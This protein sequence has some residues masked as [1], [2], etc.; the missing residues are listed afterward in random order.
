MPPTPVKVVNV[1]TQSIDKH[2]QAQG[3]IKAFREVILQSDIAGKVIK[4]NLFE[5]QTVQKGDIIVQ[6]D[7][8]VYQAKLKQAQAK[9]KHSQQ[10]YLRIKTLV[11]KGTGSA[12]EAEDAAA[13]LK[14][15]EAEVALATINVDKTQIKAPFSG[16]LGLKDV[17]VGDYITPGQAL[18]NLVDINTIMVD[19]HLP[20]KYIS[21]IQEKM[22]VNLV[23]DS[24]PG[25]VFAGVIYA[26]APTLDATMR[27]LHARAKFSNPKFLLKPGLFSRLHIILATIDKALIIPEEAL[28]YQESKF[29]VYTI[30]DG[31]AILTEVSTGAKQD[32]F[33]QVTSG[34]SEQEQVV[35]AGQIKLFDGASIQVIEDKK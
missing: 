18:V 26:I 25:K 34:L 4:L 17:D 33:I 27:S 6:L 20:E 30:K 3:E 23:A 15:H 9:L 31:K 1:Q 19:F 8:R 35:L 7:D 22:T 10:K 11:E 29:Y 28:I 32:G 21:D 14:F 5:G 2:I 12:S 24:I 13:D 16:I